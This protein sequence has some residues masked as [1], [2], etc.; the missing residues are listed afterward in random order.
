MIRTSTISRLGTNASQVES[1]RSR[2]FACVF[3]TGFREFE[4]SPQLTAS[5]TQVSGVVPTVLGG[6]EVAMNL[7]EKRATIIVPEGVTSESG[8]GGGSL[9]IP[10]LGRQAL[11]SLTHSK[12][13][14]TLRDVTLAGADGAGETRR[15]RVRAHW[16]T[17]DDTTGAGRLTAGTHVFTWEFQEGTERVEAAA[18]PAYPPPK[19]A[20]EFVGIDNATSGN[21]KGKFGSR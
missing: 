18:P 6:F 20:A 15:G 10:L 9:A 1:K 8:G 17:G 5:L 7:L 16:V 13:G 3:R 4:V 2:A 19:Y 14:V 12:D 11:R 21:W